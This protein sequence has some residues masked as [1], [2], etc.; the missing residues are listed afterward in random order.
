MENNNTTTII[1]DGVWNKLLINMIVAGTVSGIIVLLV[2]KMLDDKNQD[3]GNTIADKIDSVFD[4]QPD[5]STVISNMNTNAGGDILGA[6][7]AEMPEENNIVSDINKKINIPG[8]GSSVANSAA[9]SANII[10]VHKFLAQGGNINQKKIYG[11]FDGGTLY[12]V[13]ERN[14]KFGVTRQGELLGTAYKALL[15]G[16]GDYLIYF[17][18][19]NGTPLFVSDRFIKI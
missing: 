7:A 15:A 9:A 5:N 14:P 1:G 19:P 6:P 13:K 17:T 3:S 11:K 18:N 8:I 2:K 12:S 4:S 16:N 10:D